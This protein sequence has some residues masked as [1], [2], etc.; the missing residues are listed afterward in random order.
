MRLEELP[1]VAPAPFPLWSPDADVEESDERLE[2]RVP[3]AGARGSNVRVR[4][5]DDLLTVEADRRLDDERRGGGLVR[6]FLLPHPVPPEAIEAVLRDGV[7][8]VTVDKRRRVRAR[9][10]VPLS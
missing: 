7:L 8:T 4:L 10:R 2:I 5:A 6:S 3:M 9:R 1:A